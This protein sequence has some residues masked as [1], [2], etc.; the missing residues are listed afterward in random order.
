MCQI[1]VRCYMD[2]SPLLLEI[3]MYDRKT[4]ELVGHEKEVGSDILGSKSG[5][6]LRTTW[7]YTSYLTAQVPMFFMGRILMFYSE[8]SY[9]KIKLIH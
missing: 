2:V 7:L 6:T 3:K 1:L 5:S 8:S 9:K 4:V